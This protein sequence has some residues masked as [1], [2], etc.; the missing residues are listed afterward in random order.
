MS[1]LKKWLPL[2]FFLVMLTSGC[3]SD[4]NDN[5]VGSLI[6]TD[7]TNSSPKMASLAFQ[8]EIP[9]GWKASIAP[10]L[11]AAAS[12]SVTIELTLFDMLNDKTVSFKKTAQVEG[13]SATVSFSSLPAWP[14][15]AS[16]TFS[17]A[18]VGDASS[19]AGSLDLQNGDNL[20][21][22]SPVG[23]LATTTV[24][25]HIMQELL[26]DPEKF[27]NAPAE[28]ATSIEKAVTGLD[29]SSSAVYSTGLSTFKTSLDTSAT[30]L[31]KAVSEAK[32]TRRIEDLVFNLMR[33]SYSDFSSYNSISLLS[34]VRPATVVTPTL[35]SSPPTVPSAVP[36]IASQTVFGESPDTT[37]VDWYVYVK[38]LDMTSSW[39]EWK[40]TVVYN[41]STSLVAYWKISPPTSST[42]TSQTRPFEGSSWKGSN[43][44][45]YTKGTAT[46]DNSG[47]VSASGVQV[48]NLVINSVATQVVYSFEVTSNA[49]GSASGKV[50]F[51]D[52]PTITFTRTAFDESAKGT[53]NQYYQVTGT[54]A[55]TTPTAKT[56]TFTLTV[57]GNDTEKYEV[58]SDSIKTELTFKAD[59][60]GSG[61][62]AGTG[63]R[64]ISLSWDASG[65]VTVTVTL[66]GQ[67]KT[68]TNTILVP[69][70]AEIPK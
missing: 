38:P 49:D 33:A 10:D 13:D 21:K 51:N 48:A 42:S 8:F 64:S 30:T 52:G 23:S 28:L 65:A 55:I 27:K 12:P 1:S 15:V 67:T 46:Y 50:E 35:P 17:G 59:G 54:I 45:V 57:Y 41:S 56:V 44:Y 19:F 29:F 24:I 31:V 47:N 7:P 69:I 36:T 25:A 39:T 43:L 61:S 26:K 37:T 62:V 20:M 11:R 22:M 5:P 9:E 4:S 6:N 3:G 63:G 34:S 60:S 58:T 16:A 53:T 14:T 70:S 66:L 2:F 32:A 68:F 18:K 40:T